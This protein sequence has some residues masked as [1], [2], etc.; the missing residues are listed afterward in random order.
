MLRTEYLICRGGYYALRALF[1]RLGIEGDTSSERD[2]K[3]KIVPVAADTEGEA[4]ENST[5]SSGRPLSRRQC[6]NDFNKQSQAFPFSPFSAYA[7][8]CAR[9]LYFRVDIL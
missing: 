4:R 1:G 2:P 7:S 9:T 3:H 5:V 8:L 6:S